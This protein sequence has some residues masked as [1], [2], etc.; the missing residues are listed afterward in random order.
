VRDLVSHINE[1]ICRRQ[2]IPKAA[3]LLAAVSGG[4][5]SMV[6]L[7]ILRRLA[8]LYGWT[9]TVAH[10]NHRLRGRSSDADERLVKNTARGLGLKLITGSAEVRQLAARKKI[11]VEM[12]AR[13]LRHRFLARTARRCGANR[14][15]LAHHADDQ[16]ELFFLRLFRGAGPQGL[17]GMQWTAHSP[18]DAALRLVRPLLDISKAELEQ[19]ARG[20]GVPF[21]EDS[22]NRSTDILRNRIRHE[23]LPLLERRFQPALRKVI[24]RQI[25]ILRDEAE[26]HEKA[27]SAWLAGRRKADFEKMPVALQRR[28]LHRQVLGLG[29]MADFDL[30]EKL[31]LSETA[32]NVSRGLALVRSRNGD[33]RKQSR[34]SLAFVAGRKSVALRRVGTSGEFDGL[35]WHARPEPCTG[36]VP[37]KRAGT[38]WFD[39]DR[40]GKRVILRHWRKGD[41][42]HLIGMHKPVKLQDLFV[43]LKVP[44]TERRKRVVATTA[45][46]ELWWVEGLRMAEPFK[47]RPETRQALKWQWRRA[48]STD[49][50]KARAGGDPS[51]NSG[52]PGNRQ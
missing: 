35:V 21:R 4:V 45:G 13:E 23:L 29:A 10:L 9:I 40:V 47:I 28:A 31:R 6:L 34:R 7:E 11:S 16:I 14:L 50:R 52:I 18:G 17:C 46:G 51:K 27:A 5:D 41:R 8:P 25:E 15:V 26:L 44:A 49:V 20:E 43:N 2:L 32:V 30:I 36:R 19:F 38:E 37:L 24:L 42:F 33:V 22:S 12:A 3:H 48:R 1:S 39:A